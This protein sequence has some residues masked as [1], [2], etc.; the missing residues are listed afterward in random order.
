MNILKKF[1][2][3]I[4]EVAKTVDEITTVVTTPKSTLQAFV[5]LSDLK[6][7]PLVKHL[8]RE[9]SR[10]RCVKDVKVI[11]KNRGKNKDKGT[12]CGNS[13]NYLINGKWLCK[14]HAQEYALELLESHNANPVA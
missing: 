6:N 14:R 8:D 4:T 9:D 12:Q 5:D 3:N 1:I 10:P 13:S 2:A 7:R 11:P